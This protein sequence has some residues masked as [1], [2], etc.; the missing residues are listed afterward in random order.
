MGAMV[1]PIRLGSGE[2][3]LDLH[4][5][6]RGRPPPDGGAATD[7]RSPDSYEADGG[8]AEG[9]G[10][11]ADGGGRAGSTVV[12]LTCVRPTGTAAEAQGAY[13][14]APWTPL[15][16]GESEVLAWSQ[17]ELADMGIV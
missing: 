2:L 7:K 3:M 16:P 13:V 9:T 14:L 10:Y 11:V 1:A 17:A 15:S 8:Q 5:G 6:Q 12:D 4:R